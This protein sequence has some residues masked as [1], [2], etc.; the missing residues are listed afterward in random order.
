MSLSTK[1]KKW[2]WLIVIV[3]IAVVNFFASNVHERIDLT[4]EKRFTISSPVKK[5]LA[6][7]HDNIEI[8][9]FL[10][11]ELPAGFKN[12]AS[13]AEELL[14]EFNEYSHG[15]IH[16]KLLSADD[17]M[18]GTNR[19]YG[20]TLSSLG[21]VPINLKVQLKAGEQSQF[22]YPAALVSYRDKMLP[23]NLYSGTETVITPAELN[24][25]EA[26]LEYKFA[27][28]INKLA[29]D[30]KPMVGYAVGNGEPTPQQPNTYDL[31]NNV[32]EQNNTVFTL[33]LSKQPVI[34]DTFKLLMIVKPTIPFPD[35]E[36][37][38]IDQYVM[39]GGKVIWFIDKLEAEM[40]S[41]QIKNQV[42]AYDRGLNLDDLLFKYGV[43]INPDLIMDLQSDFLPFVVN[44]QNQFDHLRWDYFPLFESKQNSVITKNLGLV[45]GRFV[46]SIDTVNAPAITKTILLSSSDN[47]RTIATPALISGEENRTTP[48]DAAFKMKNIPAGVLLEGKFTSLYKNRV[49]A[50][51]MDSM[52]HYGEPFLTECINENKMIVIADGDIVLNDVMQDG[53]LPMGLN[54]KNAG[55]QFEYQFANK[56]FTE[57]CLDYLINNAN[58]SEARAKDYTLR[59]LDKK[60]V[61][62]ERTQWQIIN[63][64]LPLLFIILFGIIYQWWR[65]RKY[66]IRQA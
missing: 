3:A 65:K 64:A 10:R 62:A 15:R 35:E 49:S 32:L 52:A 34:P 18:P 2:W 4:N 48:E 36:K 56:D 27:Y 25:S 19:T 1:N 47:S 60:K 9:I 8:N 51:T 29:E 40:D 63:L 46:N 14:L 13:S 37:L 50:A 20:D 61:D 41:L 38:K 5:L 59:L 12:L 6:G 53:P 66:T 55:T 33:E 26:L 22:V 42:V 21:M 30:K 7:L 44:G 17:A 54:A 24:S 16:Y 23:V 58:L 28:A 31:F 43:R 45:A 39:H 11:G 57:N